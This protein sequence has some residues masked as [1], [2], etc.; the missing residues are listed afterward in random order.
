MKGISPLS[1]IVSKD[2]RIFTRS[3]FSALA[4]IVAPVLIIL[5]AGLVFNSSEL[6]GITV[7]VYS[8]TYS[9]LTSN[10]LTGFQNQGLNFDK[11]SSKDECVNSVKSAKTQICVIFPSDLSAKGSVNSIVFY[12][13]QSRINLAYNLIQ[14]VQSKISTES[15][16]IGLTMVQDLIDNL[17][18]AKKSLSTQKT[19]ISDS[20]SNL[21]EISK[22]ADEAPS[23]EGIDDAISYLN[24]AKDSSND[25]GVKGKISDSIEILRQLKTS[26]SSLSSGL[27]DIKD[28]S[29]N[30]SSALNEVSSSLN[31][32]ISS[33]EK[34]SVV[35]ASEVVSPIKTEIKS[36]NS[37]S[38][39]RDYLLPTL[40]ILIALYG[41]VLLSS[42][43]VLKEKKTKAYFR[44][45]MTPT[46][47]LTFILGS[48]ITC[49]IILSLQF[50]LIFLGVH[51][52]LK[53]NF[54]NVLPSIILVLF[55][56]LTV[57]IFIGMVVGYLFRSDET[58]IFASVLTATILMLV[59]NTILPVEAVSLGFKKIAIFNPLVVSGLALKKVM[60]FGFT[61]KDILPELYVLSG[62]VV[63][64][65]VLAYF[66]R[67][68]TK[69]ML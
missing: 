25:S 22:K 23:F 54:L 55:V 50:L 61:A 30:T 45:F 34:G 29:S 42:A 46:R 58:T 11:L 19:K 9:N 60:L 35:N 62:F 33:L 15:S 47:N 5:F 20:I 12:A 38:N 1:S 53:A 40:L 8:D 18:S 17:V 65:V 21:N 64:F 49:M 26:S 6:S 43:L 2:L 56:S 32:L 4:I 44:N 51:F 24:S 63:V 16:F 27:S 39:N 68:F 41:G 66:G 37:S 57:F 13:D 52:L 3:K 14:D 31:V 36:I 69:R 28:E 67:I 48:Y 10:I 7:G 59:S